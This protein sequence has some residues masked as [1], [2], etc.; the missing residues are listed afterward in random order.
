MPLQ[1]WY[2]GTSGK[3]SQISVRF[4]WVASVIFSCAFLKLKVIRRVCIC[5]YHKTKNVYILKHI[6][7]IAKKNMFFNDCKSYSALWEALIFSEDN[8]GSKGQLVRC[9]S[10]LKG[11]LPLK[12]KAASKIWAHIFLIANGRCIFKAWQ[13]RC[14]TAGFEK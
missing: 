14:P 2:A 5:I 12:S 9:K 13:W 6:K 10:P 4:L 11:S 3:V 7:T 8:D 1:W